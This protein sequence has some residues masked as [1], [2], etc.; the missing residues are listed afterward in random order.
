MKKWV[1]SSFQDVDCYHRWIGSRYCFVLHIKRSWTFFNGIHTKRKY[2]FEQHVQTL[3]I[4]S[5]CLVTVH[6]SKIGFIEND[7]VMIFSYRSIEQYLMRVVYN[8]IH[9]IGPSFG[10]S[11]W[12]ERP[13]NPR[14]D[15]DASWLHEEDAG[16]VTCGIDRYWE[17]RCQ[18]IQ[19]LGGSLLSN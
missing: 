3:P 11:S 18:L 15:L 8:T 16:Y 12:G 4:C 1:S 2:V 19:V 5:C 9:T 10:P 7:T 17:G 14:L 6:L 13:H